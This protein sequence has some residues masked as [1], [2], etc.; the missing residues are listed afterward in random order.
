[1]AWTIGFAWKNIEAIDLY[2]T[3]KKIKVMTV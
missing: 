3:N 1:M 2:N